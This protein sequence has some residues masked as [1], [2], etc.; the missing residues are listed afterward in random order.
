L[1][2]FLRE[3]VS[4]ATKVVKILRHRRRCID[5]QYCVDRN[6]PK[7]DITEWLLA[8]IFKNAEIALCQIVDQST[9]RVAH[10]YW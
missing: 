5:H 7:R 8:L 4:S 2:E 9:I 3:A 1:R 6:L 10:R